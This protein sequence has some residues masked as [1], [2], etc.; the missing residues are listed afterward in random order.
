[1]N[2]RV[3]MVPDLFG[4]SQQEIGRGRDLPGA[5][6]VVRLQPQRLKE[7]PI[8]ENG[9]ENLTGLRAFPMNQA[10]QLAELADQRSI[11]ITAQ[12]PLLPVLVR[13]R[14]RFHC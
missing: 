13:L 6:F 9:S 3:A 14:Y 5:E 2:Q 4:Q 7:S 1:M 10:E 8:F 12:E 11:D